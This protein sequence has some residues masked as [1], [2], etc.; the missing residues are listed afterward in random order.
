MIPQHDSQSES[1]SSYPK[2]RKQKRNR[3]ARG[4]KIHQKKELEVSRSEDDSDS[5]ISDLNCSISSPSKSSPSSHKMYADR[6]KSS[7]SDS[8]FSDAENN[9]SNLKTLLA[10]A[11]QNAYQTLQAIVKISDKKVMFG[12]WS[13]FLPDQ[14]TM[15]GMVC[16]QN[17]FTTV[18]KD[19][20]PQVRLSALILLAEML[21]GSKQFLAHAD[22]RAPRHLSF[23]SL[24][25]VLATIICEVHRCLLLALLS[26]SST[27]LL[28]Q[29][30][31]CYAVLTENVPYTKLDA[32][33]LLKLI[34]QT[35][36]FLHHKDIQVQVACLSVFGSIINSNQIPKEIEDMT[37]SSE[38]SNL[39]WII[40]ICQKNVFSEGPLP[41]II[42]SLQLLCGIVGRYFNKLISFWHVIER[43]ILWCLNSSE[44]SLQLHGA[45]LLDVLGRCTI[46]AANTEGAENLHLSVSKLWFSVLNGP[47]IV[48]LS[49]DTHKTLQSVCC[50]CLSTLPPKL[51]Q[52]LNSK[53]QILY[54]TILLGMTSDSNPNVRGAAIRCL[55]VFCLFPSLTQDISFLSD[56]SEC[57]KKSVDD[58]NVNVRFKA[59]WAL[60][61]LS[62]AL[63]SNRDTTFLCKEISAQFFYSTGMSCVHF[64]KDSDRIK[65]NAV[66]SLGNF[67]HYIPKQFLDLPPMQDFIRSSCEAL[68]LALSATFMKVC[69][70]ACYA[71]GNVFKN[72]NLVKHKV[73]DLDDLLHSLLNILK[74]PNFK[75][76]ISAAQALTVLESREL[77]GSLLPSIWKNILFVLSSATEEVNFKEI[78]HQENLNDQLCYSLC[79][80]ASLMTIDDLFAVSNDTIEVTEKLLTSMWKFG[81]HATEDKI[82][83]VCNAIEHLTS[84]SNTE[85]A[86]QIMFILQ[87]TL[88]QAILAFYREDDN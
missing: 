13:S 10:S 74:S 43:I 18:L 85:D 24:S 47:L 14:P 44:T 3:R 76:R 84:L 30:L 50:D 65:A 26:E 36:G 33:I 52:E 48:C 78:K 54:I 1:D 51:F 16:N 70:N 75:V 88:N 72:P 66:R 21:R 64:S 81:S 15:P 42:E 41:L 55:G 83:H 17:I 38:N 58:V 79:Q 35:K 2:L 45:K 57:L 12:Y 82:L 63:F 5:K 53:Q 59:S 68:K 56:V 87:D 23:T 69:W 61:N 22:G 37:F 9:A 77:Y 49:N 27:A 7:S 46:N 4:K 80:L 6:L 8:E 67:L 40:D 39:P 20:V 71:L 62:D 29:I 28:T 25:S 73:I 60:G 31:K 34:K 11:R 86:V 19:P 32:E